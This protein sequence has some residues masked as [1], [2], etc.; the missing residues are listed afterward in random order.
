MTTNFDSIYTRVGVA[1]STA[2][3]RIEIE[4]LMRALKMYSAVEDAPEDG[5][6]IYITYNIGDYSGN[7]VGYSSNAET[8]TI[9][10]RLLNGLHVHYL[11]EFGGYYD[12]IHMAVSGY[13]NYYTVVDYRLDI[14]SSNNSQYASCNCTSPYCQV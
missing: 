1:D 9:L 8:N 3:I 7:V 5:Y 12:G 6:E 10:E 14:G 2:S 13:G 11:E 4:S